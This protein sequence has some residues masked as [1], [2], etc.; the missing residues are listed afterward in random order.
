M[1]GSLR[2]NSHQSSWMGYQ[3]AEKPQSQ[4]TREPDNFTSSSSTFC[5]EHLHA[6]LSGVWDILGLG[7]E[8][9]LLTPGGLQV[10]TVGTLQD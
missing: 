6:G 1:A 3:S 7:T 4:E 5:L 10:G 9:T 8:G 2:T